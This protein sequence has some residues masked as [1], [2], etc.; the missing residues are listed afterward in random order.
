M[1]SK[2]AMAKQRTA[3]SRRGHSFEQALTLHRQGRIDEA[4]R[5]YDAILAAD[6]Q[7]SDALHLSGFLKHQQ[8][9]PIDG[10]RLVAAASKK[11]RVGRRAHELRVILDALKRHEEA[12]ES[13]SGVGAAGRRRV[14][15]Y[16]RGNAL[17][18]LGRYEEALASYDR[19][20]ALAPD[21]GPAHHNRG[22]TYAVLNRNEEALASFD[23]A[24][25]LTLNWPASRSSMVSHWRRPT[26]R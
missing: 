3:H 13:R 2:D 26:Q 19:A 21:L 23:K 22:S 9:R 12:L 8:G 15:H 10:L 5:I 20:L 4:D 18:G 17:K 7:H 1:C 11:G 6:P 14:I 25:S 16:N 24:L